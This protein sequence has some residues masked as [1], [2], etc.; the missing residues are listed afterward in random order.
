MYIRIGFLGHVLT[1]NFGPDDGDVIE[2]SGIGGG[3]GG[4]FERFEEPAE[5]WEEETEDSYRRFGFS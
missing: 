5:F 4:L 3:S 1:L 2:L